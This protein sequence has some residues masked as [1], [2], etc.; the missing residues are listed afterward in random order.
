MAEKTRYPTWLRN[1]LGG[2]IDELDLEQPQK[3][4]LTSRWLD[5]VLWTEKK[6]NKAR[7][8]YYALRLTT[9][10]GAVL[11]PA[12][13]SLSLTDD[14]LDTAVQVGTWVISLIVAVSAAIE[15][16]FHFGD[17]WRSYRRTVERLKAEGWLF[18]QLSGRYAANGA[19]HASA[20]PAFATRTERLIDTDV[21]AFLTE[22]AIERERTEEAR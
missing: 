22:V 6:A 16:F 3:R 21:D 12:L 8:W 20:Y 13:V 11:I 5:Q 7:T 1:E 14:T 19:T 10:I 2:V 15:Q 9:V 17:R 4:F 18:L